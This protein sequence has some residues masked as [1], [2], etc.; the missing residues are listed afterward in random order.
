VQR[1]SSEHKS[2]SGQT[3][4]LVAVSM[5]ALIAMAAL[6]IDVATLYVARTEAQRA[7]DA[8]ALAGARVFVTSAY[9]SYLGGYGNYSSI[10]NGSTGAADGAARA[11]LAANLVAGV[12]PT[13]TTTCTV[14]V[15]QNPQF[16]VQVSRTSLPVFLARI[17]GVQGTAV[18]ASATAEV[19][20]P[21]RPGVASP[22]PI[23]VAGVKPW[24][25]PNC[26]PSNNTGANTNCT[27]MYFVNPATG[28][29]MNSGS[30][31]GEQVTLTFGDDT[32]GSWGASSKLPGPLTPTFPSGSR[33]G[34]FPLAIPVGSPSLSCPSTNQ[35]GCNNTPGPYYNNISCFNPYQFSCGQVV[36]PSGIP[37]DNRIYTGSLQGR[38]DQ[39]TQCLI[40]AGGPGQ[41]LGQDVFPT[42]PLPH[43]QTVLIQPG[44]ENPDVP[45][46]GAQYISRSD[47][48]VTVPLFDGS[49][50]CPSG[51]S[52]TGTTTIVGFL[53][54]GV[55]DNSATPLL[56][57]AS[58]VDAVILN[59][60]ACKAGA[61]GTAISGGDVSPIPV[62]LVSH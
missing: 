30:F 52:C 49:N 50:L 60:S 24:L 62:R 21:S 45:I 35:A 38:N 29:I 41:G 39:G 6:T 10:C 57:G 26:P 47:S 55:I 54:L 40:H 53:Q 11:S 1:L 3:I 32:P 42:P 22:I 16:T 19:Y 17:W 27:T 36:G 9:T 28:G 43:G 23:Q 48:V 59:A 37:V 2:Q 46:R 31:I 7:A 33:L 8:A 5:L 13:V 51:G 14:T 15:D 61:A 12:A 4:L 34:F 58:E 20:N 25:V 18:S 56:P 44:A